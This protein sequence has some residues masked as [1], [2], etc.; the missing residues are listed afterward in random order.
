M[1]QLKF[2][3]VS[4]HIRNAK[5]LRSLSKKAAGGEWKP[6]ET[7]RQIMLALDSRTKKK[8]KAEVTNPSE[9]GILLVSLGCEK[10]SY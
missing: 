3:W 4:Q 5:T 7:M 6:L 1:V 9:P 2:Q 8:E 10:L